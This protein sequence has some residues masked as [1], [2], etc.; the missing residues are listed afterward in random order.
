VHGDDGWETVGQNLIP[1]VLFTLPRVQRWFAARRPD[2]RT[3]SFRRP[4][5]MAKM[6]SGAGVASTTNPLAIP[7]AYIMHVPESQ[8][9]NEPDGLVYYPGNIVRESAR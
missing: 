3:A 5:E 6:R 4:H 2:T 9:C 8:L 1:S 7:D